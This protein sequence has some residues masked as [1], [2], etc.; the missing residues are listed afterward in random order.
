MQTGSSWRDLPP[1]FGGCSD[2]HLRV[3]RWRDNGVW[4]RLLE[5]LIDE[6]DVEWWINEPAIAKSTPTRQ[7]PKEENRP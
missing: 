7:G 4:E 3:I 1:D 6:P 5:V 2:T